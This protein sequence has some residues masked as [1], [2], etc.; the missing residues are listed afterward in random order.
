MTDTAPQTQPAPAPPVDKAA[1][2]TGSAGLLTIV[3]SFVAM[4]SG[5]GSKADVAAGLG[6]GLVLAVG[7]F[8]GW[9]THHSKNAGTALRWAELEVRRAEAAKPQLEVAAQALAPVLHEMA[10]GVDVEA[11]K[12][13]LTAHIRDEL[14]KG[15]ALVP[16]AAQPDVAAVAEQVTAEVRARLGH[17][18][19]GPG[20]TPEPPAKPGQPE[21][22]AA[23]D[24]FGGLVVDQPAGDTPPAPSSAPPS[25]APPSPPAQE[26]PPAAPAPPVALTAT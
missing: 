21:S 9:V 8:L 25:S 17:L 6:T 14:A 20:L 18:L 3:T 1:A 2:A 26:N 7:S 10:P 22:A 15:M 5:T 12:A 19:A 23:D 16:A 4:F 24:E 11:I 13:E